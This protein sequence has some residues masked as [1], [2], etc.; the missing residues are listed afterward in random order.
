[1]TNWSAFIKL[2]SSLDNEVPADSESVESV[3]SEER[4]LS[5]MSLPIGDDVIDQLVCDPE[6]V[7][8]AKLRKIHRHLECW[9][10]LL[11]TDQSQTTQPSISPK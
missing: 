9:S 6:S 10:D 1:M 5:A 7:R 11:M 3:E 2:V 8:A 4:A